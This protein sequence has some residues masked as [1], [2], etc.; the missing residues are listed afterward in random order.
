M[1]YLIVD[2]MHQEHPELLKD[3]YWDDVL[4]DLPY[5]AASMPFYIAPPRGSAANLMYDKLFVFV[6]K[7]CVLNCWGSVKLIKICK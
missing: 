4:P 5:T 2:E 6:T 3:Q 7:W 1:S